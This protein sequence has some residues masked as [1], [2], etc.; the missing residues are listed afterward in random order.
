MITSASD[1]SPPI[2]KSKKKGR[3]A[4]KGLAEKNPALLEAPIAFL[5]L[6]EQEFESSRCVDRTPALQYC[7]RQCFLGFQDICRLIE[8][9]TLK[10]LLLRENIMN[11]M[12]LGNTMGKYHPETAEPFCTQLVKLIAMLE[13]LDRQLAEA[14]GLPSVNWSNIVTSLKAQASTQKK[15]LDWKSPLMAVPLLEDFSTVKTLGRG[16]FGAVYKGIFRDTLEVAIKIVSQVKLRFDA[17]NESAYIDKML[18]SV[19]PNHPFIC[20]MFCMFLAS[21]RG[22]NSSMTVAVT[23]MEAIDGVDITELVNRIQRLQFQT[24]MGIIQQLLMAIEHMH[25]AGFIHRDVKLANIILSREGRVKIIDFDVN[26]LCVA[27]AGSQHQVSF[28]ARTAAECQQGERAGTEAYMAP[29]VHLG[30]EFGRASDWWSVGVVFFRL[31][32]GRLPFRGQDLAEEIV[33]TEIEW[34]RLGT[35]P[36]GTPNITNLKDLISSL[37]VKDPKRRI[38]S[39]DYNDIFENRLFADT[40]WQALPTSISMTDDMEKL[41]RAIDKSSRPAAKSKWRLLGRF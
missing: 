35:Y 12:S 30:K 10:T 25:F 16:G 8:K 14:S 36:G 38:G 4:I 27:L 41:F 33:N 19:I 39:K 3:R 24:V 9:R 15:Q 34:H 40:D 20:R 7:L 28:F 22:N 31:T 6:Y 2:A 1:E 32:F 11:L 26:K 18:A 5:T 21:G 29:E 23:V 13:E 37:L 17:K